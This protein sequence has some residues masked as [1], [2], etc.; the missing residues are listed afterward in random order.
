MIEIIYKE[1]SKTE[2]QDSCF[3]IPVNI[4]Q[5]GE[6]KGPLKIYMEDF[7]YTFLKKISHQKKE[8]KIAILLGEHHY[9]QGTMYL[10]IKSALQIKDMEVSSEHLDFNDKIW[11]QVNETSSKYFPNQEILGWFLSVPEIPMALNEMLVKTH[12]D[13]F[14]GNEK[15]LYVV[16]PGE[17]EEAFFVFENGKMNR[18]PGYYIYYEKNEPMQNYMIEMNENKSIEETENIPD[19][20]VV[21]FRKTIQSNQQE[22]TPKLQ[23][24]NWAMGAYVA[25]AFLAV[26]VAVYSRSESLQRM[27][28]SVFD[29][30]DGEEDKVASNVLQEKPSA[31]PT[32]K[33]DSEDSSFLGGT[34]QSGGE[35][36][37]ENSS[38][39]NSGGAQG[40]SNTDVDEKDP[41][42]SQQT[43]V[44]AMQEYVIQKG[45]T[46]TSICMKH[47][48][49][50]EMIAE[51]CRIND[52]SKEN[53]I[54][55]GQKI[56]LPKK[57]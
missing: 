8:G 55:A 36:E 40:N 42:D 32:Q 22:E 18:Q 41:D 5:I 25:L 19:R 35:D 15:V 56:M 3:Q 1:E 50:A 27:V 37:G 14:A 48:G 53:V 30:G 24:R 54:F 11:G 39:E 28:F 10:F 46:L 45:D 20:A 21:N 9:S 31:S 29:G 33:P 6:S 12:L 16:E 4:R 57:P 23:K 49:N 34:N 7:A 51:I 26:G 2:E 47:Y 43:D 52:I 38:G 17:W 44:S 13:Y